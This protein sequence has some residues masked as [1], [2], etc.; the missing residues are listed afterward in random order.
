[1]RGRTET[2]NWARRSIHEHATPNQN[3]QQAWAEQKQKERNTHCISKLHKLHKH[4]M[5]YAK[6]KAARPSWPLLKGLLPSGAGRWG[7]VSP[8]PTAVLAEFALAR[9]PCR[10]CLLPW[11]SAIGWR[12][13]IS[14]CSPTEAERRTAAAK[15]MRSKE[16][17]RAAVLHGR[18]QSRRWEMMLITNCLQGTCTV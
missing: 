18:G 2:R 12:R 1:M 14:T 10:S 17:P 3:H 16:A 15:A 9:H 7:S 6:R 11:A 4:A 5:A 13:G 8:L